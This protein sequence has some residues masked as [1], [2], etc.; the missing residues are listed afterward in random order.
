MTNRP[1][2]PGARTL[3]VSSCHGWRAWLAAHGASE[4]EV[5]L[6]VRRPSSIVPAISQG[7]AVEHALCFGWV[8][9]KGVPRDEHSFHQRF[10]PRNPRSTWSAVNRERVDRL[11]RAGLMAEP[12]RAM[13]ELAKRTG[14]WDRL[15]QAQALVV[16]DDLARCLAADDEARRNYEAFPPSARRAVLEWIAQARRPETRARR[17]A[18]AV[19]LAGV[20]ERANSPRP[21]TTR[22]R[23]ASRR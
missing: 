11:A 20:N 22:R 13:V 16:P 12:G 15:A 17:V 5:W 1:T 3:A 4:R 21:V 18:R 6:V 2:D 14:T 7:E 8:D 23:P 10:T 19:A 9:S